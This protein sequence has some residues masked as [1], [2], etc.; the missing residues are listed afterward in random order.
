MSN[1]FNVLATLRLLYFAAILNTGR[2]IGNAL[3][4][5]T[6]LKMVKCSI[7]RVWLRFKCNTQNILMTCRR[8]HVYFAILFNTGKKKER[9]CESCEFVRK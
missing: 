8:Q 9:M 4:L 6:R 3:V 7:A 5:P 2:E 1:Y